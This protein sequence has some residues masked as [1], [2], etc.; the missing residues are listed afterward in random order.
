MGIG[1]S[2]KQQR[3][4]QTI[5][6]QE[7][8]TEATARCQSPTGSAGGRVKQ[9]PISSEFELSCWKEQQEELPSPIVLSLALNANPTSVIPILAFAAPN[10]GLSG[11]RTPE[12]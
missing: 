2:Q 3:A 12:R 4:P 11:S 7:G 6:L 10:L 5:C 8:E 9:V 1:K